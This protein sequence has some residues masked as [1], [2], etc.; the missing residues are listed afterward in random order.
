MTLGIARALAE[1]G[2]LA[3][4]QGD[5]EQAV[6][7]LEESIAKLREV[8][9]TDG[10]DGELNALG[11]ALRLLG[12]YD[13]SEQLITRSL[14]ESKEVGH[15]RVIALSLRNM[16]CLAYEQR[17]YHEAVR[18]LQEAL[19]IW[20]EIDHEPEVASTLRRLSHAMVA[21][22]ESSDQEARSSI[23]QALRLA[24]KHRLTP[25][26]LD[27][28]VSVAK[29]LS[30]EG[31]VQRP[32]EILSLAQDHET[33]THETTVHAREQ[34]AELTAGLSSNIVAAAKERGQV[35]DW[36]EAAQS[37][38]EHLTHPAWG[39]PGPSIPHNLPTQS[40]PFV[41]REQELSD[42]RIACENQT[43]ACSRWSAQ[44]ASVRPDWR[45]QPPNAC[46]T[47]K[48]T[49]KLANQQTNEYTN[50]PSLTASA[51]CH[52]SQLA[53][54]HGLCH[55]RRAEFQFLQRCIAQ[56]AIARLPARKADADAIRQF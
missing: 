16:G 35:L 50:Q 22:G 21:L 1:L 10:Q 42:T 8:T 37:L 20:Q 47:G 29:L 49:N 18:Y 25:I 55:C 2:R 6:Q 30:R 28:F 23:T 56:T 4:A 11:S 27:V 32:I 39:T 40:T 45:S 3:T 44:A 34:L 38:I 53:R 12:D 7:Y 51:L 43:A 17:Q 48:Q 14:A 36:Q 19:S 41:G 54:R 5:Y 26:V 31:D 52:S 24:I 9:S 46:S 13:T 33:S 15:P